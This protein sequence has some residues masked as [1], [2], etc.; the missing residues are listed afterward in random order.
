MQSTLEKGV[1]RRTAAR[2]KLRLP[3]IFHWNDGVAHTE[4]GFTSDVARDGALISSARC[5]PLGAD[6]R[7]EILLPAPNGTGEEVRIQ[8]WGKVTRIVERTRLSSFGIVGHFDDEQFDME[9]SGMVWHRRPPASPN[10]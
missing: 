8:C 3:V 4:G 1:N 9:G 10:I 7:V 5:P 2:Y 6:I